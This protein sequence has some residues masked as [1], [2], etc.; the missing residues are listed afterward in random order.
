MFFIVESKSPVLNS[1]LMS[2]ACYK[3]R[4]NVS[5]TALLEVKQTNGGETQQ[6]VPVG[7]EV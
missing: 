3:C 6:A 1:V 5:E 2:R 7:K 4:V